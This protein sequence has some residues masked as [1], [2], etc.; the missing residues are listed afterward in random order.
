MAL[1]GRRGGGGAGSQGPAGPAGPAGAPGAP[2]ERGDRITAFTGIAGNGPA[3][4]Q[5]EGAQPGDLAL[6]LTDYNLWEHTSE[7]AWADRG[8]IKGADGTDGTDGEKWFTYSLADGSGPSTER[9]PAIVPSVGDLALNLHDGKIWRYDDDGWLVRPGSLKGAT[10]PAGPAGAAGPAGPSGGS[11]FALSVFGKPATMA[12]SPA[13]V[14]MPYTKECGNI[15]TRS[16]TYNGG[17]ASVAVLKANKKYLITLSR[18]G[19]QGLNTMRFRILR[20]NLTTGALDE[21]DTLHN[22]ADL[23]YNENFACRE[24]SPSADVGV[25][26]VGI[27]GSTANVNAVYMPSILSVYEFEPAGGAATAYTEERAEWVGGMSTTIVSTNPAADHI[28]PFPATERERAT[29]A[30]ERQADGGVK[31]LK[32]GKYDID[33]LYSIDITETP[34]GNG[35]GW[36]KAQLGLKRVR[37][38]DTFTDAYYNSILIHGA[39]TYFMNYGII[40]LRATMDCRAN[41]VIRPYLNFDDGG[42]GAGELASKAIKWHFDATNAHALIRRAP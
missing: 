27:N 12:L 11:G 2:G 34:G 32:A 28:I 23:N 4:T 33:L 40:T 37:G 16:I 14:L 5:V 3:P 20:F 39:T 1:I 36:L 41:D 18:E 8:S 38:G 29:A 13:G 10:G 17:T 7:R 25:G 22:N 21:G 30:F 24:I 15:A 9:T 26:V 19:S 6:N 42:A 35:A 31:V